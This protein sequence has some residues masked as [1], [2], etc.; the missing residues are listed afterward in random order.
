MLQLVVRKSGKVE[1]VLN[2]NKLV[3]DK[4]I[5]FSFVQDVVCMDQTGHNFYNLGQVGQRMV[6][7]P[8]FDSLLKTKMASEAAAGDEELAM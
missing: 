3:V 5:S 1:L 2:E 7:V 4:G 6:C 8:D